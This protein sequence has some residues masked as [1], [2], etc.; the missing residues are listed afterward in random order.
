MLRQMWDIWHGDRAASDLPMQGEHRVARMRV[1]LIGV[2][3]LFSLLAFAA[4]PLSTAYRSAVPLNAACLAIAVGILV[5]TRRGARPG[6]LAVA[7][8][9]WDVSLVTLLHV[10]DLLRGDASVAVNGRVTFLGYFLALIG[11]SMRWSRSLPLVIGGVAAAQYAGIVFWS[12][13]IWP[14]APTADLLAYGQ[15]DAGTQVER[16]VTLLLFAL[17][18]RS[19]ADWAIALRTTA[20]QDPLTGLVNRR[21]FE[22]RLHDELLRAKRSGEPVSVAILDVDHFKHVNDAHGHQV[23]DSELRVVAAII[24]DALRRTDIVARWGGDEFALVMP[25]THAANAMVKLEELRA[26]MHRRRWT[27]DGPPLTLSAG[28]AMWPDDGSTPAALTRAADIR[29]F[30]AKRAGRDRVVGPESL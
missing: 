12:R 11:T 26:A 27:T 28:V 1:L 29:L 17:V 10:A 7:T 24:R 3:T 22:E 13:S 14:Q 20:I 19:I 30:D 9:T 23:G 8:S 21:T 2:L 4:G 5:A 15:F 18:C 6:W 16:V 25:A